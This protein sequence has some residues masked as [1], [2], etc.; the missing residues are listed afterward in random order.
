VKATLT[1]LDCAFL[2]LLV[3]HNVDDFDVDLPIDFGLCL[4]SYSN[5]I[6]G[7]SLGRNFVVQRAGQI[8]AGGSRSR[9][10][11]PAVLWQLATS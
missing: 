2:R 10:N 3:D 1:T 4:S 5:S 11:V 8:S 9:W 6:Y 7:L